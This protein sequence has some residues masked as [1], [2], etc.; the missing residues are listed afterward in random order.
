MDEEFQKYEQIEAYLSNKM[1]EQERI[2]FDKKIQADSEFAQEVELHA[3]A[4]DFVIE[5]RLFSFEEKIKALRPVRTNF[6]SIK[7]TLI[8]LTFISLGLSLFLIFSQKKEIKQQH[9]QNQ[10]IQVAKKESV[11]SQKTEKQ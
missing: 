3:L 2:V 10:I 7:N 1:P 9:P 8:G 6:F 11:I 4:N 5:Q